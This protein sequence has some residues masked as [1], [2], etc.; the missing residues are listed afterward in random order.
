MMDTSGLVMA[1]TVNGIAQ[2]VSGLPVDIDGGLCI[3]VGAPTSYD[4]GIGF[5]AGGRIA[6]I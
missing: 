2:H 1:S 3:E 4:Q 6:V 5:T